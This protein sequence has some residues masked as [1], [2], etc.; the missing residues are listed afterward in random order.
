MTYQPSDFDVAQF[1][2]A[3]YARHIDKPWGYE[4]HW[5]PDSLPYMGKVLHIHAGKRLSLQ[6]HDR[7]QESWMILT[8]EAKVIWDNNQG[9]L[10]ETVL[11]AGKGF[12]CL[13]G[14]RHRLVGITDCNILEVSTPEQGTTWR[15]D[16]DF[17]RP[18]ETET[19]RA[20][21]RSEK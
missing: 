14:Q 9:E 1:S 21:E 4:L 11:E 17:A 7:K 2:N 13:P 20:I 3:G 16:D 10:V 8:G 5:T 6:A 15:L 12:T 18:D 19:Q